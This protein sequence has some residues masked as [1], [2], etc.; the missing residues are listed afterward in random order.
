M[1]S[2]YGISQTQKQLM[3]YAELNEKA[4]D[5]YGAS[6]YYK[7]ALLLDSSNIDLLYKYATSLRLYN[8]YPLARYYYQKVWDKDKGGRIYKDAA[9]WVASMLKYEGEYRASSKVWRKVKSKYGRNKK[10]YEYRKA[11]QEALSCSYA[12][13]VKN[14]VVPN[15]EVQNIGTPVNTIN[16]EFSASYLD[17][18]LIF[19]SLRAVSL[20]NELEIADEDYTAK[21]YLSKKKD[22]LWNTPI[23]LPEDINSKQIH[24]ANGSYDTQRKILYFSRC[25]SL[26]GCKIYK[27]I[28]KGNTK[29][30]IEEL[31]ERINA[32]GSNTTQPSFAQI[33]DKRY[34]FFVSNRNGGQGRMDIWFSQILDAGTYSKPKNLGKIINTPDDDIS[35]FYDTLEHVLYFSSPWHLGLGG[36]DIFSIEGTPENFTGEPKNLLPPFNSQWNDMYFTIYSKHKGKREGFLTSNRL[37]SLYKKGPT[38]CNDIYSVEII[39]EEE[40]AQKQEIVT[41]EDLNKYLPVT[42]YFH[43][44]RPGPKSMDTT[45]DISYLKTYSYYKELKPKYKEEYSKGLEDEKALE[46]KLDIDDLY[47]HYIDKGVKDLNLFTK[48]LLDELNKG[49]KIEVTIKGFASPLAKTEYNVNLTKR[50]ISSLINYLKEYDNGVFI[51]YLNGTA[52]N[53]GVL[54]FVKIPFGEYTASN[55]VSDNYNDQ[56]NSVYSKGA[57]LERK[58]EIQSV[59]YADKQGDYAR[60]SVGSGT[61]DFG[62]VEQGEPLKHTFILKNTGNA[63]LVINE[64]LP[65]CECLTINADKKEIQPGDEGKITLIWNTSN[66]E[67]KQVEFATIK[68]NSFP[69]I[70]R[71]VVTAEIF[72]SLK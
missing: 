30:S 51:P 42:L 16:S 65:S 11:K 55:S 68:A 41:L 53:G 22:S 6:I 46:A 32:K 34:L 2:G 40:V 62:K 24:T 18:N 37:G 47:K 27:A 72:K 69:K 48:L 17:S 43:N 3:N 1:L 13:R 54:T 71:L 10:S 50:R 66:K 70:K 15:V 9:F 21:I 35:P 58:I 19:S 44:D 36:M 4:G 57:A 23:A 67:G 56:R 8:N 7:Q 20:N 31:P 64:L 59:T 49:Q 5:Y 33:G 45:V 38:C 61:Y 39:S 26:N 14:E 28:Y 12:N 60:L 52:S 63:P 25:D 29:V